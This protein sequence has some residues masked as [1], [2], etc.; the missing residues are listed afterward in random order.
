M[1]KIYKKAL[2]FT[3]A[4]FI[5]YAVYGLLLF[6][7]QSKMIFPGQY[8]RKASP[9]VDTVLQKMANVK[10]V[11]LKVGDARIE[12][13]Y[14]AASK[15]IKN[16]P[17]VIYAHGN[18]ELIDD[19]IEDLNKYSK[20]G[21]NYMLVEFPGYGRSGGKS[22][23]KSITGAFVKVYDWL[24]QKGG[25]DKDRIIVH[26]FSIGGGIACSLA[27]KRKV[28]ALVLQNTFAYAG[29]MTKRY[30]LP[31]IFATDLFDNESLVKVFKGPIL[32]S[33]GRSDRIIPYE[34]SLKLHKVA[35]KSTFISYN[36]GHNGCP[37]DDEEYIRTI[38]K[39]LK[40]NNII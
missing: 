22:S 34:N 1:K 40:D 39:F 23:L 13:W 16:P 10:R 17:V 29:M 19:H 9:H 3:T 15:D 27:S 11:W 25:I 5:M 37:V 18:N 38:I 7:C 6:S 30:C 28:R 4:A 36:C 24:V 21:I 33:H 31:G 14:I 26:G 35:K 2:S 8:M 32:I 12:A 20:Y